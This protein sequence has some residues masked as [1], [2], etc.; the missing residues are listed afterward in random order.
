MRL[1]K[2]CRISLKKS[3]DDEE[4]GSL[5]KL[6]EIAEEQNEELNTVELDTAEKETDLID[7][8]INLPMEWRVPRNLSL[9]NV[10]G[11]IHKGVST[12]NS[13]NLLNTWRLCHRLSLR[14]FKKL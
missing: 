8:Q 9:D 11:Q 12:R 1:T 3:A 2:R 5:Q 4:I 6:T 7:H 14:Q 10:I 13:L